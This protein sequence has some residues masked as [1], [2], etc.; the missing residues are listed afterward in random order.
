MVKRLA[1][2]G[3]W[4]VRASSHNDASRGRA[5]MLSGDPGVGKTHVAR[6]AYR[7]VCAFGVEICF[8]QGKHPYPLWLDWP[9]VAEL[10]KQSD[11][12]DVLY[13]I[14]RSRILFVDDI[15]SESD[16]FKTGVPASRLRVLLSRT[17]NKWILATTNLN[18]EAL[19]QTYDARVADRLR[20]FYWLNMA[21]VPSYRGKERG[22]NSTR[23]SH[24]ASTES[25][26]DSKDDSR[27]HP[28]NK[29]P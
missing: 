11:F 4:F 14:D 8:L 13:E 26:F 29:T 9:R 17:E 15:G 3:E 20:G 5:L 10:E 25:D 22:C 12:E 2:A 16:R 27:H 7:Y 23:I 24:P 21:G 28:Q 18:R 1:K 19:F 6:A